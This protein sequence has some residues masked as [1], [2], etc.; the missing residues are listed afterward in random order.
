MIL[1]KVL[2]RPEVLPVFNHEEAVTFSNTF[3]FNYFIEAFYKHHPL[4]VFQSG[5]NVIKLF[6]GV[7]YHHSMVI[8][9]FCVIKQH[10]LGNY[11][12][13]AVNYC[14]MCVTN[15]IKHELT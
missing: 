9:S 5:A 4:A 6:T 10:Y 7:I 8:P 1:L 11:C 2:T 14:G 15:V 12:R 3:K 13:M